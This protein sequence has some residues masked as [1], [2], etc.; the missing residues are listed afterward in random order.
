MPP[1]CLRIAVTQ[2]IKIIIKIYIFFGY[3]TSCRTRKLFIINDQRILKFQSFSTTNVQIECEYTNP[4]PV[5][6]FSLVRCLR[7]SYKFF[8]CKISKSRHP[9]LLP[10][11]SGMPQSSWYPWSSLNV[12]LVCHVSAWK[13]HP[14]ISICDHFSCVSLKNKNSHARYSRHPMNTTRYNILLVYFHVGIVLAS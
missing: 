14:R 7:Y 2:I 11:F 13:A 6:P 3:N 4:N 8:G 10:K 5:I 12:L 9:F 1:R